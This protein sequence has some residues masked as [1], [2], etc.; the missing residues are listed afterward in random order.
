MKN[1]LI[2]IAARLSDE[3]WRFV[4]EVVADVQTE[5]SRDGGALWEDFSTLLGQQLANIHKI[6]APR[7]GESPPPQM[8]AL[9]VFQSFVRLGAGFA[10]GLIFHRT[11]EAREDGDDDGEQ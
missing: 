2:G 3:E 7:Q 1:K 9:D 10:V 5:M 11:K 6:A 8:V 4:E